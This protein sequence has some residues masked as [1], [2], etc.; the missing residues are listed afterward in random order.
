[1]GFTAGLGFPV[2]LNRSYYYMSEQFIPHGGGG[3]DCQTLHGQVGSYGFN[4]T[5]SE[6]YQNVNPHGGACTSSI[7]T[8]YLDGAGADKE[9]SIGVWMK[10][11]DITSSTIASKVRNR[12]GTIYREWILFWDSAD[13]L[14][15]RIYDEATYNSGTGD[16]YIQTK[17]DSA[18]TALEDD[19]HYI[20]AT[21][22]GSCAHSGLNIYVDGSAMTATRST[23]NGFTDAS[24]STGGVVWGTDFESSQYT[25]GESNIGGWYDGELAHMTI[26]EEELSG[27]TISDLYN[28]GNSYVYQLDPTTTWTGVSD[29]SYSVHYTDQGV[30]Q[31][32]DECP[33]LEVYMPGGGFIGA[34]SAI[35]DWSCNDCG[36][37][38]VNV[39]AVDDYPGI[40]DLNTQ[41]T[42]VTDKFRIWLKNGTIS[43]VNEWP[44]S[45]IGDTAVD[46][47]Q[48]AVASQAVASGGGLDF[49]G[50]ADH[51][52][53]KDGGGSLYDFDIAA[54][55][56]LTIMCVFDRDADADHTILSSGDDDH[57]IQVD[58]GSD[59]ITIKLGTTVTTVTPIV[60]D[61]W[62]NGT[63]VL[64]TLVREA[65]TKGNIRL[66]ANGVEYPQS[67]P[68]ANNGAGEFDTLAVRGGGTNNYF[69]GKIY[70]LAMWNAELDQANLIAA[71]TYLKGIHSIP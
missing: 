24:D 12:T 64:M 10:S 30:S 53:F 62:A 44:N 63:K 49:D 22:D 59:S 1:M 60:T 38:T 25:A 39:T 58:S 16:N 66:Y 13:K 45:A 20:V 65:G 32:A 23:N 51:Y 41:V 18:W 7:G 26:W 52:D 19:W 14:I 42:G 2:S 37:H 4:G 17:A 35:Q 71:H 29:H 31:A 27:G 67:A 50:T 48:G 11:D 46:A 47:E 3:C 61:L 8:V 69:N 5:D 55:E 9:I 56:G 43:A 34:S 28:S 68:A 40:Y 15:W 57:Y 6:A 33:D 36:A 54:Q 21:Y 70:G